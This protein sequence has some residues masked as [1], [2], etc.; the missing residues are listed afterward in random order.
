MLPIDLGSLKI[1][2]KRI[3]NRIR[4]GGVVI[5]HDLYRKKQYKVKIRNFSIGGICCEIDSSGSE[6]LGSEIMVEF[7]GSILK[8]GLDVVKSKV[9]W[10]T[11]LH[12]SPQ[13]SLL[14]GIEFS[15]DIS[16]TKM[17]KIREFVEALSSP[18]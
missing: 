4:T 1:S 17:K 9:M 15:S 2:D 18:E 11:A 3:K 16:A 5:I 13:K 14:I 12:N 8:A 7:A 10:V 6:I